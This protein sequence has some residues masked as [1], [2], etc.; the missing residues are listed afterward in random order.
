MTTLAQLIA[1]KQNTPTGPTASEQVQSDFKNGLG[2]AKE[3]IGDGSL[4]RLGSNTDLKSVIN[5][6]RKLAQGL[7][8]S[9]VAGQRS[10]AENSINASTEQA[11]RRLASAQARSGVRGA[12]AGAQQANIIG[13]GIQAQQNFQQNLIQNNRNAQLEGLNSLESSVSGVAQFDISQAAK[14]KLGQLSTSLNL[15][16]LGATERGAVA[17]TEAQK[18]AANNSGKK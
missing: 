4:G 15:A 1:S 18:F 16:G 9:E 5:Q 13:Q 10:Q 6:K 3:V 12:T 7:T 8:G 2:F 17:Q 14:E 11:R